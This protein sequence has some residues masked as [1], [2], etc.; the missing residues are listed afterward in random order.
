MA[1]RVACTPTDCSLLTGTKKLNTCMMPCEDRALMRSALSESWPGSPTGREK[2]CYRHI[3][4]DSMRYD[5][6]L[7]PKQA[8]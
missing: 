1:C 6:L 8:A 2:D 7:E 5:T 4:R 3:K